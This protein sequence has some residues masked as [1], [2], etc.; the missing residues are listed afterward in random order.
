VELTAEAR[1]RNRPAVTS[2]LVVCHRLMRSLTTRDGKRSSN[3]DHP[4][5]PPHQL[6]PTDQTPQAQLEGL[7]ESFIV[8]PE[9]KLPT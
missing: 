3:R 8:L 6:L 9:G 4:R 1:R 7:V 2:R 5:E